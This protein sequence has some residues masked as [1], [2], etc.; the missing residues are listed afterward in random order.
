MIAET[1]LRE[2]R[3]RDYP[4]GVTARRPHRRLRVTIGVSVAIT[5]TLA[6]G[7]WLALRPVV[8]RWRADEAIGEAR[9]AWEARDA[10]AAIQHLDRAI[11]LDPRNAEAHELRGRDFIKLGSNGVGLVSIMRAAELEPARIDERFPGLRGCHG[12]DANESVRR[13]DA[14]LAEIDDGGSAVPLTGAFY[15]VWMLRWRSVRLDDRNLA[16]GIAAADA[17]IDRGSA[18]PTAARFA[19]GRIRVEVAARLG[20][21]RERR[22]EL[23]RAVADLTAAWLAAPESEPLRRIRVEALAA[24]EAAAQPPTAERTD[25]PITTAGLPTDR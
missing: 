5:A 1:S 24:L 23:E 15:R 14:R 18:N 12:G 10:R 25:S 3:R 13:F 21:P 22:A 11:E 16:A 8:A 9:A 2:D 17:S 4:P 7:G 20:D 6:G 19:R